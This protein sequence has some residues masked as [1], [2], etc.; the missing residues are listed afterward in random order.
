M[1]NAARSRTWLSLLGALPPV[2]VI[3]CLDVRANDRGDLV[4]TKGDQYDV[5]ESS[6]AGEVSS[7]YGNTTTY[8]S[9]GFCVSRLLRPSILRARKFLIN[10]AMAVASLHGGALLVYSST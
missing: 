9:H 8:G 10:K 5:R 7:F 6:G 2:Q 1:H 4:V 3:A